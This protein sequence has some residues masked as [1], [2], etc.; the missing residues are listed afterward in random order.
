MK[1]VTS[2]RLFMSI[3]VGKKPTKL[4]KIC[5]INIKSATEKCN[6]SV[7]MQ[8]LQC[9]AELVSMTSQYMHRLINYKF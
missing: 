7:A 9:V 2:K 1:I 3:Y 4:Y 5:N 8:S 6:R